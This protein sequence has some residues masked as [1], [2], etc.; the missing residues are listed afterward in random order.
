M[1]LEYECHMPFSKYFYFSQLSIEFLIFGYLNFLLVCEYNSPASLCKSKLGNFLA[2]K[3]INLCT[4]YFEI[5]SRACE[6]RI[7]F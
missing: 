3:G 7:D 5:D 2:V 6:I 1:F 4:V